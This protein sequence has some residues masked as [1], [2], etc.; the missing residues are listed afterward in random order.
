MTEGRVSEPEDTVIEIIQ[1]EQQ[2]EN[3]LKK[4]NTQGPVKLLLDLNKSSNILVHWYL[5]R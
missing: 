3:R 4:E 5:G 2:R 1:F